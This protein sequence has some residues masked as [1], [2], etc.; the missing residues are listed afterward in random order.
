MLLNWLME[1]NAPAT[2]E[3]YRDIAKTM[4]VDGVDTVSLEDARKAAIG[5]VKKLSTDVGIPS[6]LKEIVKPEDVEFLAQSAFDDACHP[7]NPREA[8]VEEIKEICYQISLVIIPLIQ[9]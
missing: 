4:G 5:T 6:E 3:K 2:G 9:F 8:S 7:G 1:Y